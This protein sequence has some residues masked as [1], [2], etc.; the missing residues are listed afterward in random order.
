MRNAVT[1]AEKRP[2]WRKVVRRLVSQEVNVK[3]HEYEDSIHVTLPGLN[4]SSVELVG[5]REAHGPYLRSDVFNQS[6][7][8]NGAAGITVKN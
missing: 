8:H 3:A 1:T 2:D 6:I 7:V 4:Q 5:V